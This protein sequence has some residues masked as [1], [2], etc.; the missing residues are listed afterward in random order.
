MLALHGPLLAHQA[1]QVRLLALRLTGRSERRE[2]VCGSSFFEK[3]EDDESGGFSLLIHEKL[4][5]VD[6]FS[7]FLHV[8][9]NFHV[10]RHLENQPPDKLR[11]PNE[12]HTPATHWSS[13]LK[14][15]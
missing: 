15:P 11:T 1:S 10:E 6:S 3:K 5:H 4:I 9:S 7:V 14:S 13:G 2:H 12:N 8:G